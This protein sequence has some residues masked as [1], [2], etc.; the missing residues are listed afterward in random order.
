MTKKLKTWKLRTQHCLNGVHTQT[1][2]I[3]Q[4][5]EDPAARKAGDVRSGRCCTAASDVARRRLTRSAAGSSGPS[6]AFTRFN[7]NSRSLLCLAVHQGF[8]MRTHN[9]LGVS[10]AMLTPKMFVSAGSPAE[11]SS[12]KCQSAIGTCAERH[13]ADY[14]C[15]CAAMPVC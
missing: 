7:T 12:K 14:Q 10:T 8:V 15:A 9:T 6:S 5:T 3:R 4:A 2:E 11:P 1:Y 13:T